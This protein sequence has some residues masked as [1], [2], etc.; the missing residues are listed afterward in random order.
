MGGAA[1][2]LTR[3][4]DQGSSRHPIL[5]FG[6]NRFRKNLHRYDENKLVFR[7]CKERNSDLVDV[8]NGLVFA[9]RSRCQEFGSAM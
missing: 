7:S 8:L 5:R 3:T 1:P 2:P 9:D 6:F 4:G